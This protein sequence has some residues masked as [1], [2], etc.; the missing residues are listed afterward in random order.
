M[1]NTPL[2]LYA[3]VVLVALFFTAC[4]KKAPKN[5]ANEKDSNLEQALHKGKQSSLWITD[6]G[7]KYNI[8]GIGKLFTFPGRKRI[9]TV[10][11]L[12]KDPYNKTIRDKELSDLY[13]LVAKNLQLD[14]FDAVNLIAVD[15]APKFGIQ[16]AREHRDAKSVEEVNK[17]ANFISTDH[18]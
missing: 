18:P 13:V 7:V 9:L 14:G 3:V 10:K 12:S 6:E 5:T 1:N 4:D 16:I 8:L 2:K 15:K 17:M 11:Y